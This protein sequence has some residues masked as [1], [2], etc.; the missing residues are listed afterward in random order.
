MRHLPLASVAAAV[1]LLSCCTVPV[2][3]RS[4]ATS[5][6]SLNR[7]ARYLKA[8][9]RNGDIYLLTDWT[10]DGDEKNVRGTGD[11]FDAYRHA[12]GHGAVTVPI[13]SVALFETNVI[14]QSKRV[15]SLSVM[16]GVTAAV[17]LVCVT[18][19]KTCFGSCP[20]FYTGEGDEWSLQAEGF[21][22]SVAPALEETDLDALYRVHPTS[23]TFRLR[24]KNEALETHVVRSVRIVAALHARDA[25]V[26]ATADRKFW[27]SSSVEHPT[28]CRAS[29]GDCL[30]ALRELDGVERF[31]SADRHDLSRHETIDLHFPPLAAG[32]APAG[33]LIGARQTLLSTFLFYQALAY[34]GTRATAVLARVENHGGGVPAPAAG[35]AHLLG[36]IDVLVQRHG[37]WENVGTFLENGPI[38]TDLRLL[39][40]PRDAARTGHVRLSLT[41]GLWRLDYVALAR[42][43]K[44]VEPVVLSPLDVRQEGATVPVREGATVTTGPGDV[45]ELTFRL[46][47]HPEQQE[48]FLESRG[49]YLEWMRDEWIREQSG[50]RSAMMFHAPH[51]ALRV[52]APQFKAIEPQI[53]SQFWSSRYASH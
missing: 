44:R 16:T 34:L 25:R 7:S 24:M 18:S 15:A 45:Y 53:E 1:A 8:H 35:M 29:E 19:P 10:V 3:Q 26:F 17:A 32:D 14:S 43:D 27:E 51:L 42:M 46:P 11:H 30:P 31:N 9:L 40:I 13:D 28:V 50:L 38:A 21:S 23:R 33:L 47:D 22:A 49:Y 39:P 4:F 5:P 2:R 6:S 36:G 37:R 20:T 48:L 12:I 52:L 41:R